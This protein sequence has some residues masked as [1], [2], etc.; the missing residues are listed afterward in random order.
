MYRSNWGIVLAIIPPSYPAAK[1]KK[2]QLQIHD[3]HEWF[4]FPAYFCF[5]LIFCSF[6]QGETILQIVTDSLCIEYMAKWGGK[7]KAIEIK[8]YIFD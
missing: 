3:K 7:I 1:C 4:Q 5:L 6:R 8:I 2:L